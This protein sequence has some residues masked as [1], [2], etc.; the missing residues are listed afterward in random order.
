FIILRRIFL[1][2]GIH[3]YYRAITMYIT[4]LPKAD[5]NYKCAPKLDRMT[6]LEIAQ[7][8]L[9]LLSGM[10][11]SINGQHIYCGDYIYS[12]HTMSLIMTYLVIK[13]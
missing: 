6:F 5:P 13:E 11:L 3:Y 7:R 8:V 1:I 9:K 2:I 10:G 4:V 12:G